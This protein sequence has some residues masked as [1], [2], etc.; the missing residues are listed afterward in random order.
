MIDDSAIDDWLDLWEEQAEKGEIPDEKAFLAKHCG[1]APPELVEAFR[2]KLRRLQRMN[3]RVEQAAASDT[4]TGAASSDTQTSSRAPVTKV[5]QPGF[6]PVKGYVLIEKLGQGGF[7]QVWKATAPGGHEVA[8]KFVK[9][10]KRV[11]STEQ[12]ALEVMKHVRHP[13]LLSFHGSWQV[14][15]WL[16]VAMDLADRTLLD[17]FKEATASEESPGIPADELLG[18]MEE[19]AKAIDFL[20]EPRHPGEDGATTGIQHRD[21]KPQNLLLQGGGVKV[22]DFGLAKFVENSLTGHTGSMTP[23]YSAPESFEN[24]T[25]SQSDQYA[26][27]VTYCHLRGGRLPFDGSPL[28]I[29]LGHREREPDLSMLPAKERPVIA[30][31]LAKNPKERWPDCRSLASALRATRN[32]R[33]PI[34][35]V[36]TTPQSVAEATTVLMPRVGIWKD[37]RLI[38]AAA[39]VL[40]VL[41]AVPVLLSITGERPADQHK[42][43]RDVAGSTASHGLGD[44]AVDGSSQMPVVGVTDTVS[45][46]QSIEE[47]AVQAAAKEPSE[48][49]TAAVSDEASM[50][51]DAAPVPE[52]S[53]TSS[54][55]APDS[56]RPDPPA[57]S[58]PSF[59]PLYNGRD[60]SGWEEYRTTM[61]NSR[62]S[63]SWRH[64]QASGMW[65][66][67]GDVIESVSRVGQRGF[68]RTT[69]EYSDFVLK[70][71][72]RI[73]EGGNSGVFIRCPDTRQGALSDRGM[74]VQIIDDFDPQ[75]KRPP[76]TGTTGTIWGMAQPASRALLPGSTWNTL[77]IRCEGEQVQ[78]FVN[79]E[80]TTH[81]RMSEVAALAD[82][83]QA[84]FIGLSAE[85][86][87]NEGPW[88]R[89]IELLDLTGDRDSLRPLGSASSREPE[90]TF[91]KLFNGN[92]LAGWQQLKATVLQEQRRTDGKFPFRFEPT[93]GAWAA[94]DGELVCV[95]SGAN[96]LGLIR[97]TRQFSNFAL[98]FQFRVPPQ[99]N[100]KLY[101]RMPDITVGRPDEQCLAIQISDDY[102]RGG[103]DDAARRTGAIYRVIGPQRILLRP[104][105][106]WNDLTVQCDGDRIQVLLN[107]VTSADVDMSQLTELRGLPRTGYIGF[108]SN[109]A[110]SEGPWFK[111]IV[112]AE[113]PD[114]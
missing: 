45:S 96:A 34:L 21:I 56:Q 75:R 88:F 13:H 101:L 58:P 91:T 8:L 68:L 100:S 2:R 9:L 57:A 82:R 87:T 74:E 60:L 25:S 37:Q 85:G 26:L 64:E 35:P 93:N 112:L 48:S 19:A 10:E 41:L 39:V 46:A 111:D 11:G 50:P 70:L 31:A 27:A 83:P 6:E 98:S 40:I 18:Y 49:S 14:G 72:F 43:S 53:T 5:L 59:A 67:K 78:V 30:R 89:K 73:A 106:G 84:G 1:N 110:A 17:R 76:G 3:V 16:I 71:E 47:S 107:G 104:D 79:G 86:A 23:A 24:K 44:V 28:Q 4:V 15:K 52:A 66:A 65:A 108:A 42:A 92:D 51:V 109:A 32:G 61:P 77:E 54:E 33:R 20:N 69:R 38:G 103:A 105:G 7:G 113:L 80:R 12:R 81:I 95:S 99:C 102:G 62:D 22:A 55:V 90:L 94:R 114:R 97:T 63:S 36:R 29:M